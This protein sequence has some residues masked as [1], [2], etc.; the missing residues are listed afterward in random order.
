MKW[1]PFTH[2]GQ[3]YDLTHLHPFEHAFTRAEKDEKPAE[4]F[5]FEFMFG[6]H[7]FTRGSKGGQPIPLELRYRDSR[8]TREFCFTRYELSKQLPDIVR[9][10]DTHR[11]Y[12]TRHGNFFTIERMTQE[13]K[14]VHYEVYF[15]IK[16]EKGGVMTCSIVSA[17]PKDTPQSQHKLRS[18]QIGFFVIAH[19]RR[20]GKPIKIPRQ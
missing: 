16:R 20:I 18:R 17:Y 19:N 7:T 9:A 4:T 6:L 2:Q 12:H 1:R 3:V 15:D 11:C 13:G 14:I 5:N 10:L 8:E